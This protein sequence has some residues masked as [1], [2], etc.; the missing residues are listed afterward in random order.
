MLHAPSK[1][2][3]FL[4]PPSSFL[5]TS[6]LHRIA[7]MPHLS[8]LFHLFHLSRGDADEAKGRGRRV[9]PGTE[10]PAATRGAHS[11]S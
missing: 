10:P 1:A 6:T 5:H 9:A 3:D 2:K 11:K 4:L 7:S 8:H